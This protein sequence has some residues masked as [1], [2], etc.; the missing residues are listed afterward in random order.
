MMGSK[1]VTKTIPESI[2]SG[3]TKNLDFHHITKGKDVEE[4]GIIMTKEEHLGITALQGQLGKIKHIEGQE[5]VLELFGER[6]TDL[7][8]GHEEKII[9]FLADPKNKEKTSR[10]LEEAASQ[11]ND[12]TVFKG[13]LFEKKF[14]PKMIA[15]KQSLPLMDIY[16]SS[17]RTSD[18]AKSYW[19]LKQTALTRSSGKLERQVEE[20]R[21]LYP[22]VEFTDVKPEKI[23]I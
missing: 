13:K 14:T 16:T 19:A 17:G 23:V 22:G 9:Q 12:P 7:P 5:E 4:R 20:I 1:P 2:I 15:R 6:A 18:I 3:K 11:V 8:K 21:S 10:I